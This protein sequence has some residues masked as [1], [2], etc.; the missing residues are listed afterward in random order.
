MADRVYAS[1]GMGARLSAAAT[2][3][4]SRVLPVAEGELRAAV[5]GRGRWVGVLT[6]RERELVGLLLGG[7]EQRELPRLLGVS[8]EAVSARLRSARGKLAEGLGV[9]AESAARR[10]ARS[11]ARPG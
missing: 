8:R 6:P 4:W 3:P 2:G 9:L 5:E 11:A 7:R 10:P 1:E